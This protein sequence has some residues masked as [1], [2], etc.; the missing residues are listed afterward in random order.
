[1]YTDAR[2]RARMC[3][4]YARDITK[5]YEVYKIKDRARY[6]CRGMKALAR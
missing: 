4:I 1:M 3:C 6:E 2:A 5:E